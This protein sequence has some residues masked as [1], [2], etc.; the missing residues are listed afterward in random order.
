MDS[1]RCAGGAVEVRAATGSPGRVVGIIVPAGRVAG[2]RRELFVGEGITTPADGI[3]L[4][5]EHRSS[6][7]IMVFDPVRSADGTLRI[8]HLL[9]DTPEGREAARVIRDGSKSFLS[10]EFHS[11]S[12]AVIS[13]VREIR[14]S[15]VIAAALVNDGAYNQTRAEVRSRRKRSRS[16]L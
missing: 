14:E 6:K 11:L 1:E 12:D 9:P 16:W 10:A 2:D 4:V 7:T 5:P 13:G 15:L 8:D 3:R